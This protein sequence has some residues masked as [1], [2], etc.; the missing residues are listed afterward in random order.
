VAAFELNIDIR[1]A[2]AD[3]VAEGD[4]T[5]VERD[6]KEE[7]DAEDD[8]EDNEWRHISCNIIKGLA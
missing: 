6:Q 8:C 7:D 2:L 4:E 3:A 1:P 5:V